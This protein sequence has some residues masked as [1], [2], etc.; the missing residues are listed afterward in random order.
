MSNC[1]MDD[2]GMGCGNAL[3]VMEGDGNLPQGKIVEGSSVG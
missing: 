2:A 1:G 3:V